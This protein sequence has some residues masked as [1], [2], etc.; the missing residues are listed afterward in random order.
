MC[1]Y[2]AKPPVRHHGLTMPGLLVI[3]PGHLMTG[4]TEKLIPGQL[5]TVTNSCTDSGHY[6]SGCT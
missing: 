1:M 3:R 2:M 4:L 5:G 6:P